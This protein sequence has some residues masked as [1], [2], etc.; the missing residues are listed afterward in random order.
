MPAVSLL[1]GLAFTTNSFGRAPG[2]PERVL[3]DLQAVEPLLRKAATHEIRTIMPLSD[4][5]TQV[6][7]LTAG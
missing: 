5:V 4:V 3:A 7:H 1:L 6:L 2:E